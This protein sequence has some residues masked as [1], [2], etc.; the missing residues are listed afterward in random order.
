MDFQRSQA[1]F[2]KFYNIKSFIT[3]YNNILHIVSLS[4]LFDYKHGH[5]LSQQVSRHF[6]ILSN[7]LLYSVTF[8]GLDRLNKFRFRL[9]ALSVREHIARRLSLKPVRITQLKSHI[10]GTNI[11][12]FV[13]RSHYI[14]CLITYF[15]S[16]WKTRGLS[17]L[18]HFTQTRSRKD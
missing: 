13:Y 11:S 15:S 5:W 16:C 10:I 6:T 17:D 12:M 7:L 14:C 3:S 2:P 9:W 4:T 18:H 1:S 8:F